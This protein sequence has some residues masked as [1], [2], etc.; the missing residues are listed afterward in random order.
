MHSRFR[1]ASV[2]ALLLLATAGAGHAQQADSV[3]TRGPIPGRGG[4]GGQLGGSY[5]FADGDY[6]A[7]AQP[8]L[9]FAG[10]FRYVINPH[11]GWQVSPYFTWSGYVSHVDAPFTDPNFPGEGVAKEFYLAQVLGAS[12]QLQWFMGTGRQRWHLGVGPAV[13]RVV[14]QN[15]RKVVEDPVSREL[16][17]GVHLG[18]TA[19]LGVERFLKRLPNTSIEVTAAW[20]AAFAKSDNRFISGWNGNPMLAELRVGAHYYYDFRRPKPKSTKPGLSN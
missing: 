12:G 1:A 18:A 3:A 7:G 8:R 5:M 4:I 6:S 19:E 16:H 15:H 9:V 17:S 11:W 13:Y 2:V 20:Q 10:H 14:V